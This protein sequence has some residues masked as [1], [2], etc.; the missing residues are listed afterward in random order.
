MDLPCD[1]EAARGLEGDPWG[2]TQQKPVAPES[3]SR[4]LTMSCGTLEA[5]PGAGG[6]LPRAGHSAPSLVGF[7]LCLRVPSS[8]G[9]LVPR[10]R[11]T[12]DSSSLVSQMRPVP[13]AE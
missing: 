3:G 5:I 4:P 10:G 6:G 13:S 11:G 8:R 2:F 9:P 1:T 12:S 7:S